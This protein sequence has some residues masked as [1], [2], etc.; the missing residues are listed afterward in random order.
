[1]GSFFAIAR[2]CHSGSPASNV[3]CAQGVKRQGRPRVHFSALSSN[4]SG[5][6]PFK[7]RDAGAS[8]AKAANFL[9]EAPVLDPR[10]GCVSP[11]RIR[12]K[13]AGGPSPAG[14][15]LP[16]VR[17]VAATRRS[18][19]P[20]SG[21]RPSP[22]APIGAVVSTAA[23]RTFNPQGAGATPAGSSIC[24][25]SVGDDQWDSARRTQAAKPTHAVD[26]VA[27]GRSDDTFQSRSATPHTVGMRRTSSPEMCM[28]SYPAA[29]P[30]TACVR[31]RDRFAKPRFA[32][33]S[34]AV[35][36]IFW[37]CSDNSSTP[38]PQRGGDGA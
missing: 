8:P 30:P 1:M 29:R 34:P 36:S 32:G 9:Q 27:S 24:Q 10:P 26:R 19:C 15:S 21:V 7:L 6:R 4:R 3:R 23:Q 35:V 11:S 5:S 18:A 37:G 33:A 22:S 13:P 28:P 38:R 2:D 17:G 12:S 16:C 20:E 25:R 14:A 31:L